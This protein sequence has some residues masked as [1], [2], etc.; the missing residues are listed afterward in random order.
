LEEGL[1]GQPSTLYDNL[2]NTLF[3][4]VSITVVPFLGAL[5]QSG[6]FYL[7]AWVGLSFVLPVMITI[8][9]WGL[10]VFRASV[11]WRIAGWCALFYQIARAPFVVLTEVFGFEVFSKIGWLEYIPWIVEIVSAVILGTLILGPYSSLS[12]ARPTRRRYLI[13]YL[14]VGLLALY[15]YLIWLLAFRLG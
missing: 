14:V 9:I 10:A 15:V 6:P 13:P 12:D 1:F 4:V 3:I 8:L 11:T 5:M 7:K 2:F